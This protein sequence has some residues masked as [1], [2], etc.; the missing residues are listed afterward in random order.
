MTAP[1]MAAP[2]V[3]A[4]IPAWQAGGLIGE[5]LASLPARTQRDRPALSAG[6]GDEHATAARALNSNG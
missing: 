6:D 2:R 5:I 4:G 3:V 1:D